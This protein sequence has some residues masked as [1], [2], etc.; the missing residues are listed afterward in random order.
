[1][2]TEHLTERVLEPLAT[3]GAAQALEHLR[4]HVKHL[5]R[6]HTWDEKAPR[7]VQTESLFVLERFHLSVGLHVSGVTH[8]HLAGLEA[9]LKPF[10]PLLVWCKLDDGDILE[11]S[12]ILPAAERGDRWNRYLHTLG[13][14]QVAQ[15]RH[16]RNEQQ[17]LAALFERSTLPK[18]QVTVERKTVSELAEQLLSE[19]TGEPVSRPTRQDACK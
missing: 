5:E 10:Q 17:K 18:R 8:R 13:A 3:A 16:F 12:V 14:D 11:R 19:L 2:A 6:L 1:M 4:N 15:C 7:G 9:R